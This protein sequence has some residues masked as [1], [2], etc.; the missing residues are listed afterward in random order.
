MSKVFVN[1]REKGERTRIHTEDVKNKVSEL[2]ETQRTETKKVPWM[3]TG[4]SG[5]PEEKLGSYKDT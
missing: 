4:Y 3:I 2:Q 1:L 5:V